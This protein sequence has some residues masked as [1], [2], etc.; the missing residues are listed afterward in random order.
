MRCKHN[1]KFDLPDHKLVFVKEE[2]YSFRQNFQLDKIPAG[3]T[4]T[5]IIRDPHR[6]VP[7]YQKVTNC[8]STGEYQCPNDNVSTK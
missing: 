1:F 2:G 6:A 4:H 3:F 5:F 8:A 7:S